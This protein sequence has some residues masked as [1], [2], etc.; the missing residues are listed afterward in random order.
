[1]NVN[2]GDVWPCTG[3]VD[4]DFLEGGLGSAYFQS[5]ITLIRNALTKAGAALQHSQERAP[6]RALLSVHQRAAMLGE[7]V[8]PG[9]ARPAGHS[10]AAEGPRADIMRLAAAA[11]IIGSRGGLASRFVKAGTLP[12]DTGGPSSE[13]PVSLNKPQ[14]RE[15]VRTQR[16]WA[17]MPLLC[18]RF[19]VPDPYQGKGLAG[20]GGPEYLAVP[21]EDR[22]AVYAAELPAFL[23][24]SSIPVVTASTGISAM[25]GLVSPRPDD[26]HD[27]A[28]LPPPPAR[29]AHIDSTQALQNPAAHTGLEQG[30]GHGL[31]AS[32][33][34]VN[35]ASA[36]AG[37]TCSA[38][39]GPSSRADVGASDAT[40][41][42]L[43]ELASKD[44][45]CQKAPF[46][47]RG[48]S[49]DVGVG[50]GATT[51]NQE[52]VNSASKKPQ[53]A[54]IEP[55]GPNSMGNADTVEV[56][57][58]KPM[59]IFKAIFENSDYEVSEDESSSLQEDAVTADP[60]QHPGYGSLSGVECMQEKLEKHR[61]M[62]A[63]T[64]KNH[65]DPLRQE[66]Q[67]IL[68]QGRDGLSHAGHGRRDGYDNRSGGEVN[69]SKAADAEKAHIENSQ[70]QRRSSYQQQSD[71]REGTRIGMGGVYHGDS[72][73]SAASQKG[74]SGDWNRTGRSHAPARHQDYIKE[75]GDGRS[76]HECRPFRKHGHGSHECEEA[77]QHSQS[78]RPRRGLASDAERLTEKRRCGEHPQSGRLDGP[79]TGR[80]NDLLGSSE[81]SLA[82][83]ARKKKQKEHEPRANRDQLV[84]VALATVQRDVQEQE[85]S[86]AELLDMVRALKKR[87]REGKDLRDWESP[88]RDESSSDEKR[89]KIRHKHKEKHKRKHKKK[90]KRHRSESRKGEGMH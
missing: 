52:Q 24:P 39:L 85:L 72:R 47:A 3:D 6:E 74:D 81:H 90:H 46:K 12:P 40:D 49:D 36:H 17:P 79:S 26:C 60:D 48:F 71:V 2:F 28:Q 35:H 75:G 22:G 45:Q 58:E 14:L 21:P 68:H 55:A 7:A 4:Y 50:D 78:P 77:G 76:M 83:K 80:Y 70:E 51:D 88:S 19:N 32:K 38:G 18:K 34:G 33:L 30:H 82:K 11:G 42:L 13:Q 65:D 87:S 67:T 15:V 1:M 16:D 56:P 86:T 57:V 5:R 59:D 62:D 43:D 61:D 37:S 53:S 64:R 29:T 41:A 31:G 84:K 89:V 66:K 44:A 23:R 73:V 25:A 20:S 9:T 54:G 63:H 27:A 69:V 10:S 8:L